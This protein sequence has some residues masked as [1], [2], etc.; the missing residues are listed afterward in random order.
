M[1]TSCQILVRLADPDGSAYKELAAW[2]IVYP[3]RL[4]LLV[5]NCPLIVGH[6]KVS[7]DDVV[8][9]FRGFALPVP[10]DEDITKL[11][12]AKGTYI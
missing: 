1:P 8:D 7:F 11:Y 2:G 12:D 5:H 6:V 10:P 4:G 3:P 9:E